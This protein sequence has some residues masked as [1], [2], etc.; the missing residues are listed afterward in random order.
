MDTRRPRDL[1]DPFE[2]DDVTLEGLA[3]MLSELPP[4]PALTVVT[5]TADGIA[6]IVER[7]TGRKPDLEKI[8]ARLAARARNDDRPPDN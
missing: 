7:I 2:R 5:P 4:R 1:E 3:K 6:A 8:R